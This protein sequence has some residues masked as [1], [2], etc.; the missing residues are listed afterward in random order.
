SPMFAHLV[1]LS[2]INELEGEGAKPSE[3]QLVIKAY[4]NS[5]EGFTFEGLSLEYK[6]AYLHAL[7]LA[8]RYDD[9][10]T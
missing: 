6:S 8:K 9:I 5:V 2:N 3:F 7:F 10:E 1:F 4:E